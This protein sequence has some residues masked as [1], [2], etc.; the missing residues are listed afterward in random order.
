MA[1][2]VILIVLDAVAIQTAKYNC[3]DNKKYVYQ[4]SLL[5]N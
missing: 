2:Y 3:Q 1:L 4:W 5:K